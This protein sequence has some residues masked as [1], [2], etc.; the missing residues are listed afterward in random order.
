[1]KGIQDKNFPTDKKQQNLLL[2]NSLCTYRLRIDF[3]DAHMDDGV[4]IQ[5][6]CDIA[7]PE[8]PSIAT[9]GKLQSTQRR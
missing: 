3:F 4:N 7:Q 2:K 9:D 1:M 6:V 8:M 5:F